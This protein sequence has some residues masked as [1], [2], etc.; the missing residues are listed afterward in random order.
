[1]V[2]EDL[3]LAEDIAAILV[4]ASHQADIATSAEDALVHYRVS[5]E[6]PDVLIAANRLPGA[7]GVDLVRAIRSLGSRMPALILAADCDH[8][9]VEFAMTAGAVDMMSKPVDFEDM[10]LWV[11]DAEM[12]ASSVPR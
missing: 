2:D 12:R 10:L 9:I 7:T 1:M 11:A 4:A 5:P 3:A 8:R 6:R